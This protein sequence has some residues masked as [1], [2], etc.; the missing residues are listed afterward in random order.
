MFFIIPIV[1]SIVTRFLCCRSDAVD[2]D[3]PYWVGSVEHI[4]EGRR[5]L[6]LN[7]LIKRS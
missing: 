6:H 3:N 4:A 7:L 2:N 1:F 5:H